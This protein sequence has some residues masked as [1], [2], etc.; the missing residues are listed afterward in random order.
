[1]IGIHK[2]SISVAGHRTSVSLEE[3]FWTELSAIAASRN[4]SISRLITEIDAKKTTNL[5]SEI[6]LF[7]LN[8]LKQ[9]I[10]KK[11]D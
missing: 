11:E 4:L 10:D 3:E 6:R 2:R 7:V 5:S 8:N 1:M 9:R